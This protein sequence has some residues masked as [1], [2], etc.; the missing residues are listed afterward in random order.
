MRLTDAGL[1]LAT[2]GAAPGFPGERTSISAPQNRDA[3]GRPSMTS[4]RSPA[5]AKLHAMRKARLSASK[6]T[7]VNETA[8]R[9]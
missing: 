1:P 5:S 2:V 9:R 8:V 6:D 3:L 4:E 7:G